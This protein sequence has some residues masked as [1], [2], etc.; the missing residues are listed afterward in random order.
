MIIYLFV[1]IAVC[2]LL[3]MILTLCL[4]EKNMKTDYLGNEIKIGDI[5][6]FMQIGYRG[7]MKGKITAMTD[8]KATII[9]E[10]TNTCKTKSLQFHKQMIKIK[11]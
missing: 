3:Q 9:H 10:K 7:L 4:M 8:K 11:L 2:I 5:V 6:V 1:T